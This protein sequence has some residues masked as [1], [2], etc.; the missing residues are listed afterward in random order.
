M[1]LSKILI[2]AAA[3]LGLISAFN[4]C[5]TAMSEEDLSSEQA[6]QDDGTG[7]TGGTVTAPPLNFSAA[8]FQVQKGQSS[9]LNV[10]GG[11]PPYTFTVT[12]S[13]NGMVDAG[14][15]FAAGM[16]TGV[17]QI[18]VTDSASVYRELSV[19]VVEPP[20]PPP[21]G[22]ATPFGPALA[23]NGSMVAWNATVSAACASENRVCVNGTLSGSYKY[24]SCRAP[25]PC[26]SPWN[27]SMASGTAVVAYR[28]TTTTGSC[29]S[30]AQTRVCND[31][32][33]SGSADYKYKTCTQREIGGHD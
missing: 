23:H 19:N 22:C 4:N 6:A 3:T 32:V 5:G 16:T 14:N 9:Q 10:S 29:A 18:R 20:A 27:T 28:I 12:P 25:K 30:Y 15:Q 11:T 8:S 17:V 33:L 31:G 21:A 2:V 26:T 7:G 1:K 24:A 13:A